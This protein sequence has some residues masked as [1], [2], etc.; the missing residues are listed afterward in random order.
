[1]LSISVID[2]RSH[3]RLVREGESVSKPEL[4]TE[5]EAT[6]QLGRIAPN[7][8]LHLYDGAVVD[9]ILKVINNPRT[10]R[11]EI[12][13]RYRARRPQTRSTGRATSTLTLR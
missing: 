4:L 13:R 5:A 8:P 3:R 2:T 9:H 7:W 11:T 1:M 12:T 10:S 6:K